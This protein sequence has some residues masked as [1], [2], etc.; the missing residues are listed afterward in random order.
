MIS[1]TQERMKREE[2]IS[3]IVDVLFFNTSIRQPPLEKCYE[4]AE[5]ILN[6]VNP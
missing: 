2:K 4:L 3:A 5:K 6:Q 1:E